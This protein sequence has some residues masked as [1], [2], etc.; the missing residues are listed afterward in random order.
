MMRAS[1]CFTICT[2]LISPGD[3]RLCAF[4]VYVLAQRGAPK[5]CFV[6]PKCRRVLWGPWSNAGLAPRHLSRI[7]AKT[8][9][10][11][12]LPGNPSCEGLPS[13]RCRSDQELLHLLAPLSHTQKHPDGECERSPLVVASGS[14]TQTLS[15][16]ALASFITVI[17]VPGATST[18]SLGLVANKPTDAFN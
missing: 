10:G 7:F 9:F 13:E 14:R 17:G 3:P 15:G 12:A 18:I 4:A 8:D 16:S 5:D 11:V 6:G 1:M 2:T